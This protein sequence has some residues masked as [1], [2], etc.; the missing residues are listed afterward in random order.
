MLEESQ[1]ILETGPYAVELTDKMI[2]DLARANIEQAM[3]TLHQT[4]GG[5]GTEEGEGRPVI[6][7]DKGG[8][9]RGRPDGECTEHELRAQEPDR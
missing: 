1:A 8:E 7:V 9:E 4:G 5:G 6:L 3:A 2:L